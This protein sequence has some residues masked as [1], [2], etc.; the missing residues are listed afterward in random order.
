MS[1]NHDRSIDSSDFKQFIDLLV[2]DLVDAITRARSAAKRTRNPEV[3]SDCKSSE[4]R[5]R[6][7]ADRLA[8]FGIH[9]KTYL[10]NLD[11]ATN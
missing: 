5:I 4:G 10:A 8:G 11:Q 3:K 2:L 1:M 9:A 6:A 7:V